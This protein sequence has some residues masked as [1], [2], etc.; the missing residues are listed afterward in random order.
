MQFKHQVIQM[1]CLTMKNI[2]VTCQKIPFFTLA[3]ACLVHGQ[4]KTKYIRMSWHTLPIQ[5]SH[6]RD[7][8]Y[9]SLKALALAQWCT[10]QV[11]SPTT[12]VRAVAFTRTFDQLLTGP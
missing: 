9:K 2:Y 10:V 5:F 3:T 4:N 12:A 8:F 1:V 11:G 7:I 6:H